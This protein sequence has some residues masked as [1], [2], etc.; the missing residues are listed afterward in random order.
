MASDSSVSWRVAQTVHESSDEPGTFD[1]TTEWRV[2]LYGFWEE[3]DV[4]GDGDMV[5]ELVVIVA[6]PL[7]G[8]E[9]PY[10]PFVIE[11]CD[12]QKCILR[13]ICFQWR[14]T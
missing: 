12:P 5:L 8:E 4:A 2:D 1:V 11:V 7:E 9:W 13:C 10:I 14:R 3:G 6:Y